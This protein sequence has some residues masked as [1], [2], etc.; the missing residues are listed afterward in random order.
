MTSPGSIRAAQGTM[1]WTRSKP[2][3]VGARCASRSAR[4]FWRQR[5]NDGSRR[6][7]AM[8]RSTCSSSSTSVSRYWSCVLDCSSR[9]ASSPIFRSSA[10]GTVFLY[11][12]SRCRMNSW[13]SC[14]SDR[15][16]RRT[17]VIPVLLACSGTEV[18]MARRAPSLLRAPGLSSDVL[19]P[20]LQSRARRRH[21]QRNPRR[22]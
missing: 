14:F 15:G 8:M 2:Q 22:S 1:G 17:G 6:R 5:G 11:S 4:C 3:W 16:A 13:Y 12:S 7:R 10:R 18:S 19:R 21:S 20:H 9:T